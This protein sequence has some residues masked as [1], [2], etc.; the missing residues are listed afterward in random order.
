MPSIERYYTPGQVADLLGLHVETVR[1]RLRAGD[2]GAVVNLGSAGRP[3]YRLPASGV[4]A[5]LAPRRLFPEP[6][7]AR[8]SSQGTDPAGIAARTVRELRRKARA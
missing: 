3:D 7:P 1:H 2:L 6:S 4:N 8:A 5:H